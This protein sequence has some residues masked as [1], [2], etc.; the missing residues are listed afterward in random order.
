MTLEGSFV[1]GKGY[2]PILNWIFAKHSPKKKLGRW[3]VFMA[4]PVTDGIIIMSWEW[5]YYC[6][7]FGPKCIIMAQCIVSNFTGFLFIF[8]HMRS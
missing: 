2:M 5:N 1:R 4:E 3:A 6:H 7:P 8:Y